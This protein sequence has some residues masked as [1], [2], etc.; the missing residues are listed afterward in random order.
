MTLRLGRNPGARFLGLSLPIIP[1]RAGKRSRERLGH[2]LGPRRS[3]ITLFPPK[4]HQW[5]PLVIS[6]LSCPPRGG[7]REGR[8]RVGCCD[9]VLYVRQDGKEA[10][11]DGRQKRAQLQAGRGIC[12]VGTVL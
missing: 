5:E 7:P 2:N 12:T 11:R 4:V 8:E 3:H 6:L 10:S 1:Q 9:R